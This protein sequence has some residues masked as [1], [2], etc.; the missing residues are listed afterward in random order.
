MFKDFPN[1]KF[2][3]IPSLLYKTVKANMPKNGDISE[4]RNSGIISESDYI[5]IAQ[6]S[7]KTPDNYDDELNR[8]NGYVLASLWNGAPSHAF[9]K[10]PFTNNQYAHAMCPYV[11]SSELNNK[12]D[13]SF[14][15]IATDWIGSVCMIQPYVVYKNEVYGYKEE[16]VPLLEAMRESF[17]KIFEVVPITAG[18]K[19]ELF[20]GFA[21]RYCN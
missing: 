19:S 10:G 17:C 8:Y 21:R 18:L 15:L 20:R 16:K 3:I 2:I 12:D 11:S 7:I 1:L 9:P 6:A 13:L 14:I 5:F 4:I